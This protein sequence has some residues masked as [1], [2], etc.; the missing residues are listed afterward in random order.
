MFMDNRDSR[1]EILERKGWTRQ[2]VASEP[3][4]SEAVELYKE[5]GY[6][7]HLEPMPVNGKPADFPMTGSDC[8]ACFEG[9]EDQYKIVFTRPKKGGGAR[10][11]DLF[12]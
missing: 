7:V 9:T 6:E 1:L 8:I 4:L 11:D 3:R 12:D 5:T 10:D 2:F